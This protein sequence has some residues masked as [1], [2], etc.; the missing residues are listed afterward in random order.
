MA[1]PAFISTMLLGGL[2][3]LFRFVTIMIPPEWAW[4][5]S[6]VCM[7]LRFGPNCEFSLSIWGLSECDLRT[8]SMVS[9]LANMVC[10][11]AFHLSCVAELL[12]PF[13][14]RVAIVMNPIF[15]GFFG[16]PPHRCRGFLGAG[17]WYSWVLCINGV[18]W[19]LFDLFSLISVFQ[20]S[21]W[22]L[23]WFVDM[24]LGWF[25]W[26]LPFGCVVMWV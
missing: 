15:G 22:G 26:P 19:S 16:E 10:I 9:L 4:S 21:L 8:H 17:V 25:F 3:I 12:A 14:F 18:G 7:K 11:I 2:C 13:T 24:V 5:L 1:L 20:F 6:C 23:V